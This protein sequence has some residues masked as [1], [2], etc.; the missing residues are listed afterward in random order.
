VID[1]NAI[2]DDDTRAA[3]KHRGA[4]YRPRFVDFD[5]RLCTG[6]EGDR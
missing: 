2:S 6:H 5:S 3:A 1:Q 4:T